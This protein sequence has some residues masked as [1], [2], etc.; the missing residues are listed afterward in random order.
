[1]PKNKMN[2]KKPALRP[3]LLGMAAAAVTACI[4]MA[5]MA[6]AI[7]RYDVSDGAVTAFALIALAAGAFAGG[8]TAAAAHKSRGLAVGGWT[9]G[10]VWVATAV[11]ALIANGAQWTALT[12]IKAALCVLCGMI[13]GVVGVNRSARR[14]LKGR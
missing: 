4:I 14:K 7:T 6:I 3:F 1:M 9:G 11:A 5:I 10:L 2:Q 13:G 12:P 8:I